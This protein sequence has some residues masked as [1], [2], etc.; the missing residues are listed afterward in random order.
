MFCLI[1]E[2]RR[3]HKTKDYLCTT[4]QKLLTKHRKMSESTTTTT[5]TTLKKLLKPKTMNTKIH[6]LKINHQNLAALYFYSI[7]P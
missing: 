4:K 3:N 1:P 2:L 5:T 7:L 6:K